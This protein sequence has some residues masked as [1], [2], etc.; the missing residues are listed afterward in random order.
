MREKDKIVYAIV[1]DGKL[2]RDCPIGNSFSPGIYDSISTGKE[3]ILYDF[4][5]PVAYWDNLVNQSCDD[6]QYQIYIPIRSQL[7]LI[8]PSNMLET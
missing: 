2:Y 8:W 1:P 3:F 5:D 6:G 4:N 7:A